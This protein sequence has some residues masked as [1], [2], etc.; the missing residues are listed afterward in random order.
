M[1]Y[2]IGHLNPDSDAICTAMMTARWLT[3]RGQEAMAFRTGK[4]T[5][6][7]SLFLRRRGCPF[8]ND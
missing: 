8:L 7:R 6:R 3:L 5:V 4:P 1:I 2:V